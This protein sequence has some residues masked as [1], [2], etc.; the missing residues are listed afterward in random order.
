MTSGLGKTHA[1]VRLASLAGEH[2]WA[3]GLR[4]F[5]VEHFQSHPSNLKPPRRFTH[6]NMA[7]ARA[8]QFLPSINLQSTSFTITPSKQDN[9]G[10][11][12][13]VSHH[14]IPSYLS[15][16]AVD[17]Q[18]HQP[19]PSIQPHPSLPVFPHPSCQY[20]THF[21][22]F[23]HIRW[24]LASRSG[25]RKGS[26]ALVELGPYTPKNAK[27]HEIIQCFKNTDFFQTYNS[28]FEER[29]R[30]MGSRDDEFQK[31]NW[32]VQAFWANERVVFCTKL[33]EDSSNFVSNRKAEK[34][35]SHLRNLNC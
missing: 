10:A 2:A 16:L 22:L 23:S 27:Y 34:W 12:T 17:S 5:R 1:M 3:L 18:P 19:P 25:R 11:K 24:S 15:Q 35:G 14:H 29:P 9:P 4:I 20:N 31:R 32:K 33:H 7:E 26:R 28:Q 21:G 6:V 13:L 8:V 30:D